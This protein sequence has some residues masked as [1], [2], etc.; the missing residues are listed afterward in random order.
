MKTGKPVVKITHPERVLF[1]DA[2]ITKG[3]LIHYYREISATMLP[4]LKDR[5]VTLQ[6]FPEGIDQEGFFQKQTPD[7]FPDWIRRAQ[8]DLLEE[9][10]D[11]Q[12]VVADSEDTLVYLAN[13]A[14]IT[15]HAWLSRA[16]RLH[17]P[18]RMIFDLD[19]TDSD[20]GKLRATARLL[21]EMLEEAGL[22]A[23]LMTTGS[24]GLHV[25]APLERSAEFDEVRAFAR[26]LAEA[27]AARRPK[28]LTTEVRKEDRQGRMFVDY[29]RNSYAQTAVSPYSVRA[30]PG[31]TVATPLLWE[32]LDERGMT[33]GRFNTRNIFERLEKRGDAWKG[34]S[35]QAKPLKAR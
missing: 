17:Y 14:V 22:A 1:P 28:E 2:G 9:D 20:F 35:A 25:V 5:P 10:E 34:M 30:K 33:S 29:L 31:A 6:R 4:Y 26:E 19:P 32:E 27:A 12:Q 23:F 21:R 18:D 15:L 16:D 7:Y 13:Q 8:I 3:D 24:R 11:Q